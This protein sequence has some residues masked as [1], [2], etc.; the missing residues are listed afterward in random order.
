[1]TEPVAAVHRLRA[2]TVELDLLGADFAQKHSLHPTDIRALICLLDADR[3]GTRATPGWLGG[4]LGLESASVTAL[5]DRMSKRDLVSR[6][7][8]PADR[9]RVL[10]RVTAHASE[11]GT[12][13]FGPV[14]GRAVDELARFTPEQRAT[15]DDFLTTM[16]AVV[17][18]AREHQSQ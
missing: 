12:R 7:A 16:H 4:Q 8:D 3:A 11:L 10:L 6:E 5:V 13:F 15:I 17:V 2:L 1:M 14:I 18:A 9:R